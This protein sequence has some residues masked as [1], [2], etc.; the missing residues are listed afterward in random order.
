V[1]V[2]VKASI[3]ACPQHARLAGDLGNAGLPAKWSRR[4]PYK[5]SVGVGGIK[6]PVTVAIDS[7]G[8]PTN[9]FRQ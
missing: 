5:T 1:T 7:I 9:K 2:R 3:F 4:N 8:E 6:A